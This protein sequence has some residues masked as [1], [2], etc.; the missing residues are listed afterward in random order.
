MTEPEIRRLILEIRDELAGLEEVKDT[1]D[2]AQT[3]FT[4]HP[5]TPLERGGIALALHDF[6]NGAE[7]VLRRV[8]LELGEGLPSGD[9]WHIRLLR[10]MSFELHGVRPPLLSGD[11][12]T[13]LEEYLRF[14]HV[15]RHTYGQDLDWGR[16]EALLS[17]FD[18]TYQAVI[19]DVERFVDFLQAMV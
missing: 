6:Y 13:G 8:A 1:L 10:N 11:T 15:V 12:A 5:P 7:N 17:R 16:I 4:R 14:R 3:E 2:Q 18:G 9:D 19:D